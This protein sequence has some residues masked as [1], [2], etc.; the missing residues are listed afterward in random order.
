MLNVISSYSGLK[1][2]PNE[3]EHMPT[4]SLIDHKRMPEAEIKQKGR[5]CAL[6]VVSGGGHWN[7]QFDQITTVD[8]GIE[9]I[10][11]LQ[12][13][14]RRFK[15]GPSNIRCYHCQKRHNSA[16]CWNRVSYE[17]GKRREQNKIDGVSQGR[18]IDHRRLWAEWIWGSTA[19]MNYI[20][21]SWCPVNWSQVILDSGVACDTQIKFICVENDVWRNVWQL[22]TKCIKRL[23]STHAPG[24]PPNQLQ[25]DQGKRWRKIR[26]GDFITSRH[27]PSRHCSADPWNRQVSWEGLV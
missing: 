16:L 7:D 13:C 4:S 27:T 5:A 22:T 26:L 15:V 2:R 9:R 17:S 23:I 3:R 1:I 14:F 21:R 11:E 18:N 10:R 20:Y 24:A 6:C 19:V 12:S 8:P 25:V